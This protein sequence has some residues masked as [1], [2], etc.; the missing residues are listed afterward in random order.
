MTNVNEIDGYTIDYDLPLYSGDMLFP[1]F[2]PEYGETNIPKTSPIVA[3]YHRKSD[4]Q[5]MGHGISPYTVDDIPESDFELWL[6]NLYHEA[7]E[8]VEIPGDYYIRMAILEKN[9]ISE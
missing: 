3:V 4:G 2:D 9:V 7:R 6:E 8:K 1:V 5:P